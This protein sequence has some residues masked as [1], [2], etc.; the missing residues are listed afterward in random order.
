MGFVVTSTLATGAKIFKPHL[1]KSQI[2]SSKLFY[3]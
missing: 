2:Y 3:S 1:Q